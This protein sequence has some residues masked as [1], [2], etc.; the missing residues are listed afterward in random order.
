MAL[1]LALAC[2]SCAADGTE[3]VVVVDTDMSIPTEI[4]AFHIVITSPSGTMLDQTQ[5][6]ANRGRLPLTLG[7]T[8]DGDA[9]GPIE[10]V[11]QGL[12]AGTIVVTRTARTTLVRN[13]TRMLIMYLVRACIGG[14]CASDQTCTETGCRARLVDDLPQW[15]GTA[16]R[17][18]QDGGVGDGGA[19]DAGM[20]DAATFDTGPCTQDS[21]CDDHVPCTTDH[22]TSTHCDHTPSNAFCDDGNPCTDGTCSA[23]GCTQANNAGPCDDGAF[24]N[25]VDVCAAGACTHPG[26]PCM[27]P[28][29]C[30]ETTNSCLG[31]TTR[32]QCSA[33]VTGPPS[34]CDY[35]DGC[36]EAAMQQRTD[37]TYACTAGSCVATPMTVM[38]PC[39]RTT[40][41]TSCGAGTCGAFGACS[42]ANGCSQSGTMSQTCTD[43]T[44]AAGICHPVMR[45][46]MSGCTRT[47][48]G[49]SCGGASCAAYGACEWASTCSQSAVRHRTCSDP[50]CAASTCSG[51]NMRTETDSS[52]TRSTEGT[53]CG[54]NMT[55]TSGSC[56][57][58]VVTLS[59]VFGASGSYF[60]TTTGSG[61]S[62][63]FSN[64]GTPPASG[65]ITASSNVT[66][67]GMGT[68]M[69]AAVAV[70]ASGHTIRFIDWGG[71][72]A[73]L[74]T[75]TGATVSGTFQP[76]C[77]PSKYG[78]FPPVFDTM[79]GSGNTLLIHSSDGSTGVIT[80]TCP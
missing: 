50:I 18:G 17:L 56:T 5:E 49:A 41:G 36:D 2:A 40:D 57:M 25:G 11:A 61:H 66:F 3:L 12:H 44:C 74:I 46:A 71:T 51:A 54:A 73:A 63:M 64:T 38:L 43:L 58:C 20:H 34:S 31:C 76:S 48:D 45:T 37:V 27:A 30:D 23:S 32:V 6:V 13:E 47:T 21:E 39:T 9:L 10:V 79:T 26:D 35:A 42:Y 53:T 68:A 24:C 69:I 14:T 1:A 75:V 22:C 62:L 55:C 77:A 52:C 19:S 7:I 60:T 65:S 8:T 59:G 78:C 4:D 70:I 28:T 16:P 15:T 72:D 33:D 29:T 67:S 80:F